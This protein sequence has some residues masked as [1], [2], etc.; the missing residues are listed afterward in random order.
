MNGFN[1]STMWYYN[2][3]RPINGIAGTDLNNDTVVNDRPLYQGSNAY[4]GP[5]F[6][7]ADAR[8]SRRFR[9]TER[10]G[11]EGIFEVQNLTNT[12]SAD[13]TSS[14]TN[15]VVNVA[16]LADFRRLSLARQGRV[17][18]FGARYSF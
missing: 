13:C 14:C 3:G 6:F 4:A 12:V 15:A 9:I 1:L 5:A 2:T 11:I 10:H 16:P 8:L 7:Q 17:V 18:Q